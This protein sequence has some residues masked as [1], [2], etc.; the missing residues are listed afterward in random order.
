MDRK[1]KT[2]LVTIVANV[3]LV[4]LKFFLAVASGSIALRASAFHSVS[5]VFVSVFVLFGLFAARW[6]TKRRF[7]AGTIEN[8]VALIVAGLMFYFAFDIFRDVSGVGEVP[9]LKNIWP[10]IIGALLT[11]AITYF[12]ARYKEYVG[13]ATNSIS[14]IASAYHSRM[15][16]Y[17]SILVVVGLIAAAVG[18]PAAAMTCAASALS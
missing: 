8:I 12:T 7:Q 5:D 4:A 1:E 2:I 15:D 6:E 16:L 3:I 11:I 10:V 14:L 18:L 13:R 9:D 17:A